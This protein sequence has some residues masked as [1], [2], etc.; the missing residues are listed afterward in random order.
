MIKCKYSGD[1]NDEFCCRCDGL[2]VVET[3]NIPAT[4]CE[5]YAPME[6]KVTEPNEKVSISQETDKNV[7]ITTEYVPCG[8]P[9]CIRVES[10][11]SKEINGVWYKFNYAEERKLP[12]DCNLNAEIQALWNHANDIVDQQVLGVTN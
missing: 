3:S 7:Q 1:L 5:G 4:E 6:E 8:I 2:T 10:G 12:E 11:V 9:T